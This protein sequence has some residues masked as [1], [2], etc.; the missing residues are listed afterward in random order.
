MYFERHAVYLPWFVSRMW[1]D[2]FSTATQL[3]FSILARAGAVTPQE[4]LADERSSALQQGFSESD[5]MV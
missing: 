5:I 2:G 4:Y 3:I 1:R